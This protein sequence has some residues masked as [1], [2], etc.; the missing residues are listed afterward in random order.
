MIGQL[1]LA[2]DSRQGKAG[3][4]RERPPIFSRR[5]KLT[6][7]GTVDYAAARGQGEGIKAPSEWDAGLAIPISKG[8]PTK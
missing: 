8:A 7:N 5:D 6:M 1:K 2:D 4:R 3:Q